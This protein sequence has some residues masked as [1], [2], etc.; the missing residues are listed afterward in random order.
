MSKNHSNGIRTK[1]SQP[2]QAFIYPTFEE[3]C[4]VQIVEFYMSKIWSKSQKFYNRINGKGGDRWYNNQP[5]GFNCLRKIIS[6]IARSADWDTNLLWSGHSIRASSVTA[7]INAGHSENEVK[8]ISSHRSDST[9]RVYKRS[10]KAKKRI[11]ATL[12]VP[13]TSN[14]N[15]FESNGSMELQMSQLP[16]DYF[17]SDSTLVYEMTQ[18]PNICAPPPSKVLK[19]INVFKNCTV[20]IVNQ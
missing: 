6:E 14:F 5:M 19:Q 4:P 16:V 11:S 8:K 15:G 7:L 2:K 9:L 1:G 18:I 20:H 12:A 13:I 3:N 17:D 10:T